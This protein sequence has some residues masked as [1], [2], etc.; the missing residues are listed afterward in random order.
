MT[1]NS[2]IHPLE[3][4][5]ISAEMTDDPEILATTVLHDVVED[6]PVEIEEIRE[7][8]GERVA[9]LVAAESEDKMPNL[10]PTESWK[11]RKIASLEVLKSAPFEA[12]IIVLADKLSNMRSMYRD[13][14]N[15]GEA[16]WERFNQKDKRQHEWY[17]RSIVE[18]ILELSDSVAYKEYCWL[19]DNIFGDSTDSFFDKRKQLSVL[20]EQYKK[21]GKIIVAFDFDD[22]ASPF[23]GESCEKV[24]QLIRDLR[25][26][27]HLI[28]FTARTP[29]NQRAA[30][31]YLKVNNIPYDYINRE[32]NGNDISGKLFYNQLLDDKAGLF[33][34]YT[35]LSEFLK[36][37]SS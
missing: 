23:R 29:E 8:F 15:V 2:I 5:S 11:A 36:K 34:S 24:V 21:H 3:A 1:I 6:T 10:S 12:K 32:W 22:T 31:A 4:M 18:I 28:C 9:S 33:E 17:H 35:I 37:V 7:L 27:A 30:E 20:L 14:Q 19:I 13:I 16:L 26:Y 25:P